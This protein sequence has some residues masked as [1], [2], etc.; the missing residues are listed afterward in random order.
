M[1]WKRND[2]PTWYIKRKL[3]P[4]GRV[5][6]TLATRREAVAKARE[7]M[8]LD[9]VERGYLDPVKAWLRGDV[10][11]PELED[12]RATGTLGELLAELSRPSTTLSTAID[13]CL[14]RKRAKVK[15]S[16]VERYSISLEHFRRFAN[17]ADGEGEEEEPEVEVSEVLTMDVVAEFRRARLREGAAKET[18][19]NDLIAVSVLASLALDKGWL[20]KRP[21]ITKS[22]PTRR[23]RWLERPQIEAYLREMRPRFR[24]L[25]ELLIETGCR[26]GQ[27]EALTVENLHVEVED[28]VIVLR[29]NK[30]NERRQ[31]QV[32]IL[33]ETAEKL[34]ARGR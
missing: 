27:A 10:A 25:F 13:A 29:D 32:A 3:G 24:F 17:P 30:L 11:L 18:V 21:K 14:E 6:R 31:Y 12:A 2:S 8:L 22:R 33:P 19:N 5:T 4:F 28:P 15:E 20:E 9:F 26:L 16:T 34:F 1:P 7:K 23:R